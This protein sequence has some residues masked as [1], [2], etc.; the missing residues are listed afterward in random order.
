LEEVKM[1][2]IIPEK[3]IKNA[4]EYVKDAEASNSFTLLLNEGSIYK[5]ASLTPVYLLNTS[6][7]MV[8]VTSRECM[9]K[10]F[11]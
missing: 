10:K 3:I 9:R 2:Q 4:A 8:L 5:E 7:N 1:Y 6:T 11:H